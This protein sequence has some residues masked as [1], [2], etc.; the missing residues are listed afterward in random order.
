M[1][2]FTAH[3]Y[4]H[5]HIHILL[6]VVVLPSSLLLLGPHFL[7]G[8]KNWICFTL[9]EGAFCAVHAMCARR[10]QFRICTPPNQK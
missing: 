7:C 5:L 9:L 2:V 4:P 3:A 1:Y 6:L 10:A 8:P